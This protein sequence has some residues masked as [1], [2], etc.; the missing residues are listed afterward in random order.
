MITVIAH[1][2]NIDGP[3][4][5]KENSPTYVDTAI[6]AGFDVE[7]DLWLVDDQLALGHDAPQYAVDLTWL[8]ER[9]PK[10]WI[11]CKNLAALE[12]MDQTWLFNYFWHEHDTL[13]LTSRRDIW[14][15]PGRQPVQDSIAVMP[16][17]HNDD[18][19]RCR[20]VCTD[21]P[22]RYCS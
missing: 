19:S 14:V 9:Y 22:K 20:G 13:T 7:I 5:E 8:E 6:A 16:E 15:Y 11:H 1:R 12:Y 2:G 18:V 10:L 17:I 3:N 4:P 21:Y